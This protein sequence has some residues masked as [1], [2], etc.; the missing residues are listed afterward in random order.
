MTPAHE[1]I[2]IVATLDPAEGKAAEVEQSCRQAVRAVH[3]EPGCQRFA[4][5]RAADGSGALVLIEKWESE[6]ALDAH[7]KAPAYADLGKKLDG[8]LAVPPQITYL[9]QL[10]EGDERLG[11]V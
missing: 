7:V 3:N 11:V 2:I 1:P 9:Q 10:P 5:H 4:L 8:A 6:A